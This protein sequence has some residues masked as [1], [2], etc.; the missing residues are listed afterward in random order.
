M[1]TKIIAALFLLTLSFAISVLT[2]IFGWGLQPQS[3]AVIILVGFFGNGL[4]Q[5]LVKKVLSEKE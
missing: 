4:I 3:W 5:I 1:I 2:L